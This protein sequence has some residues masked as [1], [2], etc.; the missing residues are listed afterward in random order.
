MFLTIE[1]AGPQADGLGF[2]LHKHPARLQTFEQSFGRAHVFY[3]VSEPERCRAALLLEVDPVA[4][5]RRRGGPAGEGFALDQY[6]NDRPYAAS[7]LLSV[8]L[9]D[10]F[11]TA[12]NGRCEKRPEMVDHALP[13]TATLAALSCPGGAEAVRRLFEPLGYDVACAEE[14]LDPAFPEWGMSGCLRVTLRRAGPLRELL[15]HLYVLVPVLDNAKHYWVSE[16]EVEKLLRRGEGWLAVHPERE[17]I[18]QCYL[19]YQKK[20][21]HSA[22]D[23]LLEDSPEA[24]EETDP[25][26]GDAAEESIERPLNLHEKRLGTV[27]AALK[28][29][30]AARVLDLGC[31]EGKLLR[32][33]L[34]EK[35]FTEVAG[36]EV[37][38]RSLQRAAERLR[39]ERMPEAQRRRL[40][41]W[42]GSLMY[43]DERLNGFDAAALVEVIE[44]LD[45]PRLAAMER[46]VFAHARPRTVV[47]T[48]PN[49]EYNVKFETLSAGSF[50][51][52][53]HRFEWTRA[54]FQS[55]AERVA[56]AHGYTAR[57]SQIGE[58]DASL[59]GPSQMAVFELSQTE[60]NNE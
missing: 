39:L 33:L 49:A 59:G 21:A 42:H 52:R 7:S 26:P 15:A 36:L 41:L 55:W 38:H 19:R 29:S 24:I 54:E 56:R 46:V 14:P 3:P 31:G 20:L 50:R 57:F 35:Q 4:L 28:Q 5:V 51:H 40:Q 11:G 48:T 43:R 23:R 13:L 30:G 25:A 47:I 32:L 10:V 53:D 2:L 18:V 27:L 37:S 22:L 58:V 45:P 1:A 44:H 8:T 16:D 34:A 60:P 9:A 17:R 6:V 12:L